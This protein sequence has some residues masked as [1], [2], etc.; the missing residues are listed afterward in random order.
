M[1]DG[2]SLLSTDVRV[3]PDWQEEREQKFVS[4][5]RTVIGTC[6]GKPRESSQEKDVGSMMAKE[7]LPL[8]F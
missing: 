1:C 7:S 5:C 6:L 8:I 2:Q 4:G 3:S